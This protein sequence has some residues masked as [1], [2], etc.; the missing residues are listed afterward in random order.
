MERRNP[1]LETSSSRLEILGRN[2]INAGCYGHLCKDERFVH[3]TTQPDATASPVSG[4]E[5]GEDK[6]GKQNQYIKFLDNI[7]AV[8]NEE[9]KAV[10]NT[11]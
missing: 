2:F 8:N 3:A 5:S 1:V 11:T 4:N 7:Y 9:Y 10:M 6:H